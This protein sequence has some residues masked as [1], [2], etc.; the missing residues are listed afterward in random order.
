MFSR[1]HTGRTSHVPLASAA[2]VALALS[3][4]ACQTGGAAENAREPGASDAAPLAAAAVGR[5][6]RDA[7]E[8][9]PR[10]LGA[11]QAGGGRASREPHGGAGADADASLGLLWS[12]SPEV[13]RVYRDTA[14]RLKVERLP[15]GHEG[16]QCTWNF[17]DGSPRVDGCTVGHTF[18]GGQADQVVTLTLRDGDWS[19]RSVRTVPLERLPVGPAVGQE[20]QGTDGAL[21]APPTQTATSFRLALVADSAAEGGVPDTVRAALDA[22][23]GP[24]RPDLVLHLGGLVGPDATGQAWERARQRIARPLAEA[25]VP[26]VWSTSP[27]DRAAH[28]APPPLAGVQPL[29]VA[30]YPDR[31][32]FTFK[33]A[34]FLVFGLDRLDDGLDEETLAWMREQLGRARV[35]QARFVVSYL[36]LHKL[37]DAHLGSLD[38]KFRLYEIF[39]RARV[40]A[41][42]SAGYRVYFRG[43]YGALP[44]V[45]VGALAPPGGKLAGTDFAQ[46]TSL[47]VMDIVDGVPERVFGVV[48]PR[49]DKRFDEG[50]LPS[51]VEV[52]TR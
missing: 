42:L 35:Y 47:A 25:G 18:R 5:L 45:S 31:Y 50:L 52:Y 14:V 37:Q 21:P 43:R 12:F 44:V 23:A 9:R 34:F 27:A 7:V 8:A 11:G 1:P 49:F 19:W 48:G 29:D 24:L 4:T 20:A 30:R 15:P 6:D 39:L 13:L 26:T 17:G 41:L 40:T 2:L 16:A 36:P 33:G 32:T 22:L 46:P 10:A 3:Q 51:T 28:P 38:K